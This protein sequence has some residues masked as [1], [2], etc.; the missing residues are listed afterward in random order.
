MLLWLGSSPV[1][2]ELS[3]RRCAKLSRVEVVQGLGFGF[4]GC[5]ESVLNLQ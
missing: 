2:C 4:L 1:E 5:V 3:W